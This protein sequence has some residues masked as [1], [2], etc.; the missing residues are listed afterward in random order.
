MVGV[1]RREDDARN[2]RRR[3]G[4]RDERGLVFAP[5]RDS[6]VASKLMMAILHIVFTI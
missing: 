5:A 4:D 6:T 2:A 3:Q 1:A